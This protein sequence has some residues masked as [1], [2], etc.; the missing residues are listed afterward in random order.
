MEEESTLLYLNTKSWQFFT[1][2]FWFF[3]IQFRVPGQPT[4]SL[5][6]SLIGRRSHCAT[7]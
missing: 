3:K 6:Y 2:K 1:T 4:F 7:V 5:C